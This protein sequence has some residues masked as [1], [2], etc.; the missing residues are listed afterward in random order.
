MAGI[1]AAK[2]RRDSLGRPR[3]CLLGALLLACLP[4]R[5]PADTLNPYQSIDPAP[6]LELNDLGKKT[7][8]LEDY[9]GRV[10]LVNFWASWCTPCIMEMPSL[11][12]LQDAMAGK[13]FTVLAVN[14]GESAGK[15]WNFA[16]RLKLQFTLLLDPDRRTAS[17]WQ[18]E[19]YPSSFLIDPQGRIDYVAVGAR[20]WDAPAMVQVIEGMLGPSV[21]APT[22]VRPQTG[23]NAPQ[24]DHR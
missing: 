11:Q 23:S 19:V 2:R 20:R 9:R 6:A 5:V 24:P 13:P 1:R 18:V 4:G 15:V 22:G 12:R 17:A 10:V 14:V 7:H 16:S 3:R 8:K 21:T